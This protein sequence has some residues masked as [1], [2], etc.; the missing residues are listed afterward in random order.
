[1]SGSFRRSGRVQGLP[2]PVICKGFCSETARRALDTCG[3]ALVGPDGC[4][5]RLVMVRLTAYAQRANGRRSAEVTTDTDGRVAARFLLPDTRP[6]F[7]SAE[8]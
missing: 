1:M 6:I 7:L 5:A 4:P 3:P 8:A 2:L